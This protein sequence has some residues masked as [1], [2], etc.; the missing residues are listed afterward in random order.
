MDGWNRLSSRARVGIAA[1]MVA[2]AVAITALGYWAVHADYQV[3]FADVSPRD[4]AT[5][6][7]ELERM[8][9][10]YQLSGGGNTI[11]VPKDM[12]YKTRLKLMG[13]DMPL[14][15]AVG[16][17]V[18]NNA[19]FGMTDFVQKVNYQRAIQGELTRT[20]LSID[21]IQSARVHLAIPE[22]GLFKKSGTK[23][24][25]SVT[26]AVKPGKT[27]VADQ[28]AGI[29][30]LVAAS[31]PDVVAGDVTVLNQHGVVLTRPASSESEIESA[32]TQ[33]DSKRSTEEY[34]VRKV[35]QVLDRTFGPGQAIASV[36]VMLNLDQSRTTTE[37]ILPAKTPDEALPA[38]VLVREKQVVR[39]GAAV[40]TVSSAGRNGGS[41]GASNG[42]TSTEADY[43]VGRR[44]Q[45]TIT[46]AGTLRRMTIAVVV[47]KHLD[48]PELEKLKEVVALA[49]G[50]NSQRGDA[51]VVYSMDRFAGKMTDDTTS[52]VP[53]AVPPDSPGSNATV[54][55]TAWPFL[56]KESTKLFIAAALLGCVLMGAA[57]YGVAVLKKRSRKKRL[58]RCDREQVL[59][60]V[61]QWIQGST[62]SGLQGDAK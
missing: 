31:V 35:T 44:V 10:P 34:L 23:P 47:K 27:L 20:I 14:H 62:Q 59:I 45:N 56:E 4:A 28:V 16:F 58:M 51:V 57:L 24:K 54:G 2:I 41:N 42:A 37:E 7:A 53:V 46:A 13:K 29:Q 26:L 21:D 32:A 22:Q 6:T 61:R 43:Q 11:L 40:T 3:L 25:A 33:L 8:K 60:N 19:D 52:Q 15:G 1:G 50:F 55:S 12:V 17:E 36:D 49:A 9:V 18:F 30:R 39:E 48:D 38:G 5:M